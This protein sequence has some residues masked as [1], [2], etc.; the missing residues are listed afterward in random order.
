[1]T[2]PVTAHDTKGPPS[3]QEQ[4]E[5]EQYDEWKMIQSSFYLLEKRKIV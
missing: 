5:G 3:Q 4:E 2:V 1:V